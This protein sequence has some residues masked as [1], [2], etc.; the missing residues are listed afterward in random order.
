LSLEEDIF[1]TVKE[2]DIVSLVCNLVRIPS[3]KDN[4]DRER[5]VAEFIAHFFQQEG[6]RVNLV[7]II[8]DRPN[9][10]AILP[11]TG[12]GKTLILNGHTDTVPPYG[13]KDPYNAD[14]H[15]SRIYG[16]GSCDMKAGVACMM[17]AMAILKR[18]GVSLAGDVIFT[19]VINEELKSEGT[20]AVV[21]SGIHAD[22]AIVGE[23]TE[24]SIQLGHR[25]LEWIDVV[26]EGKTAHGGNPENGINAISKAA[27]FIREVEERL[28]PL[29][30]ERTHPVVGKASMNFGT[31][32]GGDQPSSVA[33]HCVLQI[34]RRTVPGETLE[35][36]FND[37]VKIIE[38]CARKDPHFKA[39]LVRNMDN[40]ATMD[41]LPVFLD[42]GHPLVTTLTNVHEQ[43]HE[44]PAE[45][46]IAPGWTDASL[47][48]NYGGIPAVNY[49]PG[50][51]A[52]AHTECEYVEINHLKP[53]TLAYALSALQLCNSDKTKIMRG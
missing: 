23:P 34:D 1:D 52:Q 21:Q 26:F 8:D 5:N 42:K 15:G 12:G 30:H 33:G 24:L 29:L 25:G 9:V 38:D 53:A 36:V 31:I 27:A 16:R 6:I 51:L 43:I 10:I 7:P 39:R 13:M 28:Q 48:Q 45:L 20:E 50:S 35:R 18:T 19:G 2:D 11:G 47:L 4:E 17:Y 32:H 37:F 22:F 40:M 46:S 3:H 44:K 41:H 49:G 14:I